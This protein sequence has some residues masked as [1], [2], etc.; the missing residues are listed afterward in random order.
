MNYLEQAVKEWFEF[1]GYYVRHN[2]FMVTRKRGGHEG[3]ADVLAIH[4]KTSMR[5][6]IECDTAA[7]RSD[8]WKDRM[9]RKLELA[10]R[11]LCPDS[12]IVI[13]P[14]RYGKPVS[15]E[16]VLTIDEFFGMVRKEIRKHGRGN[17][18]AVREHWPI[19][20]TVQMCEMGYVNAE[21]L[22]A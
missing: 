15:G 7:D 19:I 17:R 13:C 1:Q 11:E 22:E 3:E 9:K 2:I 21:N 18:A 10:K 6:H 12:Q 14:R 5:I 16:T 20:R 4:P 8:R